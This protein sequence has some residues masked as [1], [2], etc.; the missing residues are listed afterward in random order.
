[1]VGGAMP[2]FVWKSI[3]SGRGGPGPRSRHGLVYDRKRRATVLFGGMLGGPA[4]GILSDTW[5]L[6]DGEWSRIITPEH[7][8]ARDR[9]ALAYDGRRR[10]CVLFGGQA[11]DGE[12][13]RAQGD[14][15]VLAKERWRPCRVRPGPRPR[16]GHVLAFD[17]G[18]G[19]TVLFGGAPDPGLRPLRDT[20]L[21]DGDSWQ[22]VSGPGPPARRH[23]A[24]AY[25]PDLKGCVLHGGSDDDAGTRPLGDTWLF[26][27]GA[28]ARLPGCFDTAARRGHTLAYHRAARRLVMFGGSGG[29]HALLVRESDGWRPVE[30]LQLPPRHQG[31]PLAWDDNLDGLVCHGGEAQDGGHQ[32]DTTWVLRLSAAR[33]PAATGRRPAAVAA[34]EV[35]PPGATSA[36]TAG[37]TPQGKSRPATRVN[38]NR[39]DHPIEVREGFDETFVRCPKCGSFTTLP[40]AEPAPAY[41][42]AEPFKH[43]PRCG[44]GLP[45]KAVLCMRCGY[46]YRTGRV[47]NERRILK[48]IAHYWG[49]AILLRLALV[50]VLLPLGLPLLVFWKNVPA[51]AAVLVAWSLFLL[52]A[53][54]T[55]RTAGL[56]RDRQGKSTLQTRQWLCFIPLASAPRLLD[57]RAMRLELNLEGGGAATWVQLLIGD[58]LWLR[59][60][61]TPAAAFFYLYAMLAVGSCVL[62]LAEDRGG[63]VERTTIYRCRSEDQLRAIADTICEVAGVGYSD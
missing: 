23:A 14:M 48:P 47:V 17:E 12:F 9:V 8:P 19:V 22:A 11:W 61:L 45:V 57:R 38:C 62:I 30:G 7:P 33:R 29:E 1:M 31:A 56:R 25:D 59:L 37:R 46:D 13:F 10:K 41:G 21:F 3:A 4:G 50:V 53:A 16:C 24:L 35:E 34:P 20:W 5:E 26:R 36:T 60:A 52:G 32:F 55:F 54:G 63:H 39:C 44:L 51:A 40:G 6:Y 43:C 15:W 42:C 18:A 27:D 28:W 49:G 2:H 58:S